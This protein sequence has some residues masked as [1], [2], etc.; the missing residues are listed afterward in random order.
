MWKV[1]TYGDMTTW[2]QLE[3][4]THHVVESSKQ[5]TSV[6][7]IASMNHAVVQKNLPSVDVVSA[8]LVEKQRRGKNDG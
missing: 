2:R 3:L 5:Q 4:V 7:A 8:W 6:A 1:A